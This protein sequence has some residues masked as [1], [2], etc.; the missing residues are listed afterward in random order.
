MPSCEDPVYIALSLT[1]AHEDNQ[2]QH[3][4]VNFAIFRGFLFWDVT[5]FFKVTEFCNINVGPFQSG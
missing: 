4:S 3:L 5:V 1:M 2:R